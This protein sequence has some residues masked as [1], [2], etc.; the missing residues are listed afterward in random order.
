MQKKMQALAQVVIPNAL[1]L[2]SPLLL[3]GR[4]MGLWALKQGYFD[5]FF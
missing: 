3:M 1:L 2:R 4:T 5:P